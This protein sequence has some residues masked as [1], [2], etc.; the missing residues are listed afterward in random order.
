MTPGELAAKSLGA[1]E[2]SD[3]VC[4]KISIDLVEEHRVQAIST[5]AR[6]TE[7]VA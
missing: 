1:T 5:M 4:Q 6:Y 2:D 3:P 7:G